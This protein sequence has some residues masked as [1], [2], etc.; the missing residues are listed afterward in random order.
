MASPI[1][2]NET[3]KLFKVKQMLK[4][5]AESRSEFD[6]ENTTDLNWL[7]IRFFVT[8][9]PNLKHIDPEDMCT[10]SLIL[11]RDVNIPPTS[12]IRSTVV[13]ASVFNAMLAGEGLLLT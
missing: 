13:S 2:V 8:V 12:D 1:K 6:M 3:T 5:L 7:W 11:L 10:L 9:H 4:Y